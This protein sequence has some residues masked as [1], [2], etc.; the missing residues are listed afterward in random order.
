MYKAVIFQY[1][2]KSHATK[3]GEGEDTFFFFFLFWPKLHI[4]SLDFLNRTS[5]SLE[6]SNELF[7]I[8]T[9]MIWAV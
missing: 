1:E 4:N 7:I 9:A 8:E 5:C 2:N 6:E 3:E